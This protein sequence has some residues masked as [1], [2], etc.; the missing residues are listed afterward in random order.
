VLQVVLY[1]FIS[2]DWLIDWS[3]FRQSLSSLSGCNTVIMLSCSKSFPQFVLR[4]QCLPNFVKTSRLLMV[5]FWRRL[6]SVEHWL[7]LNEFI[8]ESWFVWR[9][10]EC[11]LLPLLLQW[12]V[13]R[14]GNDVGHINKVKLYVE[15]AYYW[16]WWRPL[17]GLPSRYFPATQANSASLSLRGY[18]WVQWMVLSTVARRNSEFCVVLCPRPGMLSCWLKSVK[19]AGLI[20]PIHRWVE[21]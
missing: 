2:I 19:G 21:G 1:K 12:L 9:R 18:T 15:P 16:N 8:S 14:T 20:E 6:H 13:W 3:F 5:I 11:L 10:D 17:A 7:A 4:T